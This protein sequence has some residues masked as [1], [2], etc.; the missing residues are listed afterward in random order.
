MGLGDE[1][2]VTG[3]VRKARELTPNA[4][5]IVGKKPNSHKFWV[6]PKKLYFKITL[7]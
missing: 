5:F 6:A 7:I 2:M 3:L 1:I 4:Q